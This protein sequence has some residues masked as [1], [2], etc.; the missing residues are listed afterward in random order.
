MFV[1]IKGKRKVNFEGGVNNS[2]KVF[3]KKYELFREHLSIMLNKL[4]LKICFQHELYC[5]F[6]LIF[7]NYIRSYIYTFKNKHVSL[8]TFLLN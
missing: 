1:T 6:C 4:L 3:L 7:C 5:Y 8:T 2:F